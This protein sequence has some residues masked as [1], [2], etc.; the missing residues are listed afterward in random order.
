MPLTPGVASPSLPRPVSQGRRRR[1]AEG[2]PGVFDVR[3]FGAK[4]DG[5]ADDTAAI[6]RAV[7]AARAAGGGTVAFPAGDYLSGSV[8]LRSDVELHLGAGA[9]IEASADGRAYDPPEENEWGDVLRYQDSGHSHWHDSLLWGEDL[10]NVSITGPG[11]IY[12]RGLNRGDYKPDHLDPLSQPVGN[13]AIALK[14]CRNVTLRDFTIQ[15]GGWFGILATG[16]DNLTIAGLRIDTNRDGMDIDCCRNVRISRCTVNSPFDD[17]ICLKSSFALGRFRAT[18]NVTISDCLV[19]G[20]DEGTL[21]DG[22]C[23]HTAGLVP[24]PIGRIKFGTESNGGFKAIA[25]TNCIFDCSRGLALESV[26]GGALQDVVISN[27]V[28]RRIYGAP[29]F[30][31]LG[32]RMRGPAGTAVGQPAAGADQPRRREGRRGPPGHP[33]RRAR[34]PSGGGRHARQPPHFEFAG[35]G[36]A[37]QAGR[38]VPERSRPEYPEPGSFGPTTK[39][40]SPCCEACRPDASSTMTSS[41]L[42]AGSPAARRAASFWRTWEALESERLTDA[43]VPQDAGLPADERRGTSS[44]PFRPGRRPTPTGPVSRAPSASRPAVRDLDHVLRAAAAADQMGEEREDEENEEDEEQRLGDRRGRSGDT[45]EPKGPG[46]DGKDEEY[47]DP[48]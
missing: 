47:E 38:A 5:V 19:S 44:D 2:A 9:T 25:I 22:T 14:N 46:E 1:A 42:G 30:I 40:G 45:G 7:E 8:H 27:V 29:L 35:G 21:L 32:A 33:H 31:R 36:T 37:A 41:G 20:Y 6:N 3:S 23:R 11:R 16:V 48:A 34:G 13:K 43:A 28:M 4:G 18:E 10:E 17:A 26:D 39:S 15:H 24:A 12:G